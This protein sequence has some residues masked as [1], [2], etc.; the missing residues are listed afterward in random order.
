MN[1]DT[2]PRTSSVAGWVRRVVTA[3]GYSPR[4]RAHEDSAQSRRPPACG[5]GGVVPRKCEEI[6]TSRV[7]RCAGDR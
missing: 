4:D 6:G 7:R 2:H 5:I 3:T 1:H